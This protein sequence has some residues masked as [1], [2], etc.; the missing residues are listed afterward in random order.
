LAD[1]V[2]FRSVQ[3][4]QRPSFCQQHALT[5]S[6]ATLY[7]RSFLPTGQPLLAPGKPEAAPD[8][9][10]D[11]DPTTTWFQPGLLGHLRRALLAALVPPAP[12]EAETRSLEG[13]RSKAAQQPTAILFVDDPP[14]ATSA[15]VGS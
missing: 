11:E 3:C 14:S 10:G 13:I 2:A 15:Q 12:V 6:G 4:R 1:V 7:H 8:S 5:H 9:D